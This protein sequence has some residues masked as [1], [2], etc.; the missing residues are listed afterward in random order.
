[1]LSTYSQDCF[2]ETIRV[3]K[4]PLKNIIN[5]PARELE[6]VGDARFVPAFLGHAHYGPPGFV[7][8]TK[9]RKGAQVEFELQRG[10]VGRK[11]PLQ[12]PF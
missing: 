11:K 12:R 7:A 9:T 6:A 8:I 3:L 5:M 10:L 4:R 1:M 2:F